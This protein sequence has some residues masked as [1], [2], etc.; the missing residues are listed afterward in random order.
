[1]QL[2]FGGNDEKVYEGAV[3]RRPNAEEIDSTQLSCQLVK[4]VGREKPWLI[5]IAE[6]LKKHFFQLRGPYFN[7][8]K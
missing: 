2:G 5:N 6:C 3:G 1:M 8:A 7:F 4:I